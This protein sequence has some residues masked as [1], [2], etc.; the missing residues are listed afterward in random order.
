MLT[1]LYGTYVQSVIPPQIFWLGVPVVLPIVTG[2]AA[3]APDASATATAGPASAAT[4]PPSILPKMLT[5][6]GYRGCA[7]LP[8]LKARGP[9]A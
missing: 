7:P 3:G 9:G 2:V 1:P 8:A 6:S 4:T 5:G